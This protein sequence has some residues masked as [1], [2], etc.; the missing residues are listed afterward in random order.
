MV[1][2]TEGDSG[3]ADGLH[4]VTRRLSV[5]IQTADCVPVIIM[6][7][8]QIAAVHAGWRGLSEGILPLALKGFTGPTEAVIG[9][10]IGACCYEVG[11]DLA[12][13]MAGRIDPAIVVPHQP[14][15]HLDLGKAAEIQLS[16]AGSRVIGHVTDCTRCNAES[17][18]SYRRDGPG[19]GRNLS[20]G[21]LT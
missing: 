20:F 4:S 1:A 17:L 2:A 9:P 11:E 8:N 3:E 14:R 19:A 16:S 18:W 15:P 7:E 13:A 21:W 6:G 10:H 12:A 5:A